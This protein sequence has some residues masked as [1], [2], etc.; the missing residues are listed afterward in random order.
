M[1]KASDLE[2]EDIRCSYIVVI[3][4]SVLHINQHREIHQ[5][6]VPVKYAWE[7]ICRGNALNRL[8]QVLCLRFIPYK[9]NTSPEVGT[10]RILEMSRIRN[11]HQTTSN[12]RQSEYVLCVF[13]KAQ[14]DVAA[15]ASV[16]PLPSPPTHIQ[17]NILTLNVNIFSRRVHF[18]T[19][20]KQ[21]NRFHL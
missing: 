8:S 19:T 16:L 2:S 20:K 17:H 14:I 1:C 6:H 5:G 11:I 15:D 13:K 21:K 12:A 10:K 4:Y 3:L 7:N 9:N 18:L